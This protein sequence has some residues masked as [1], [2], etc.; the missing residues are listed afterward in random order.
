M[1]ADSVD[2]GMTE[3]HTMFRLQMSIGHSRD[4]HTRGRDPSILRL[5]LVVA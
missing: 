5:T 4:T 3:L 1:I 2:N